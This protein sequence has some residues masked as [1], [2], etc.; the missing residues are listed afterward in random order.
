MEKLKSAGATLLMVAVAAAMLFG[1]FFLFNGAAALSARALPTLIRGAGL[2][3]WI[4]L[5]L[6]ALLALVPAARG[7]AGQGLVV[8]SFVYGAT[9]WI[10][11][12]LYTLDVWGWFAVLI[13]LMIMGVGIVPVALLAAVLH[14]A[15]SMAGLLLV[16]VVLTF[17][18]R[19][20]GLFL[21]AKAEARRDRMAMGEVM[22]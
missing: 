14:G 20:A 17:G 2:V 15:W 8:A 10:M 3:T 12:L 16:G 6:L 21:A 9:L 1:V 19:M 7:V 11:A 18:A 13:G 4:G 22:P 5:P